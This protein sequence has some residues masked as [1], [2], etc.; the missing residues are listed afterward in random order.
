MGGPFHRAQIALAHAAGCAKLR[1][2]MQARCLPSL[3]SSNRSNP[4]ADTAPANILGE[5]ARKVW[6]YGNASAPN[7]EIR[8]G[9]L[10]S[11]RLATFATSILLAT[12]LTLSDQKAVCL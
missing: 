7:K 9:L 5:P 2:P 11:I 12:L 1:G 8:A 6:V 10:A 3:S 4:L